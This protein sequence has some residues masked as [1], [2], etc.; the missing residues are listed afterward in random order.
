[1]FSEED[2]KMTYAWFDDLPTKEDQVRYLEVLNKYSKGEK[3]SGIFDFRDSKGERISFCLNVD[4]PPSPETVKNMLE[5]L[6]KTKGK[7][8]L[9]ELENIK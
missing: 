5:K 3:N 7:A 1:M 6:I 8:S 9:E 2:I 4:F